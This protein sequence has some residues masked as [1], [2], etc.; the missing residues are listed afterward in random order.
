[1][2]PRQLLGR[3][4][5]A[6]GLASAATR[7]ASAAE[8]FTLAPPAPWVDDR[9]LPSLPEGAAQ[10]EVPS[11]IYYLLVDHQAKVGTPTAHYYRRAWTPVSNAGLQGASEIKISFDPEFERLV[12]H[13]VRLLRR[14]R[15]VGHFGA[16]DVK[17]I[18]AESGLA[19]G[20]YSGELTALV[21]L[22]DL[23]VGDTVEWAYTLEGQNPILDGR[24]VD[25]L[26][27]A[28]STP[29][30]CLRHR[31]LAPTGRPLHI[32]PRGTSLKPALVE[33]PLERSY[34]WEALD[35]PAI[36]SEE[37][38]PGWFDPFPGRRRGRVQLVGGDRTLVHGAVRGA[39]RRP[40]TRR[41]AG[42]HDSR[43]G[44]LPRGRSHGGRPLRPGRD[45]L[46]RHRDRTQLAPTASAR[47]DPPPTVRRLQGQVVAADGPAPTARRQRPR[48]RS[49]TR[50]ADGPS[51]S[52]SP[53]PSPSITWWCGR[54]S[55]RAACGSTRP[56]H[57][58]VARPPIGWRCP[59]NGPSSSRRG[60][61]PSRPSRCP[62][63]SSPPWESTR[64]TACR[65]GPRRARRC[66]RPIAAA[67]PTACAAPWRTSRRRRWPRAI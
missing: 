22:E 62:S 45:P 49:S 32:R 13:H 18:Q 27:L 23:R 15:D 34:T 61:P 21:F 20:L 2:T 29:V 56:P 40:G 66:A 67:K 39:D 4:L 6:L 25:D 53:R 16:T 50:A 64:A 47:R 55:A 43:A 36:P 14:G 65:A 12:I 5:L 11:G 54:A 35:V 28:F 10:R 41:G 30:R 8:R 44:T 7:G 52:D 1:M 51:I 57:T 9:P 37:G 42:A 17:V 59:S 31:V 24:F 3:A 38:Q 63:P 60:P 48:R 33:G 46:S 19:E 26:P 58:R